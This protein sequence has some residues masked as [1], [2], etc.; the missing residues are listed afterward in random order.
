MERCGGNVYSK[1]KT[2]SGESNYMVTI[3]YRF[4]EIHTRGLSSKFDIAYGLSIFLWMRLGA[5]ETV[6]IKH[7]NF[8]AIDE[9]IAYG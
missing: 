9:R 3:K 8:R 1:N 4:P 2:T 5:P 7:M 6:A